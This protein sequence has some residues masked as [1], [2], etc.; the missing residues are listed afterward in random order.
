MTRPHRGLKPTGQRR[1]LRLVGTVALNGLALA[2]GLM[3][4]PRRHPRDDC[5]IG[6]D[7]A[8]DAPRALPAQQQISAP[9]RG[10]LFLL[11]P[12]HLK[13]QC[14]Y[15]SYGVGSF[16]GNYSAFPCIID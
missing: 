9:V 7:D 5:G 4:A 15:E 13:V 8:D 14:F 11:S 3:L 16:S 6:D 1:A 10:R 2:V 12:L